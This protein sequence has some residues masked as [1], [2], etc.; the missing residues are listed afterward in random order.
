MGFSTSRFN[1]LGYSGKLLLYLQSHYLKPTRNGIISKTTLSK[2]KQ[3]TILNWILIVSV[4]QICILACYIFRPLG[5]MHSPYDLKAQNMA[6]LLKNEQAKSVWLSTISKHTSDMYIHV[7]LTQYEIALPNAY[8]GDMGQIITMSGQ[9]C[10]YSFDYLITP[11]SKKDEKIKN[12]K[13]IELVN[14][15]SNKTLGWIPL[16]NL[17]H[18]DQLKLGTQRYDIYRV[19]CN[20]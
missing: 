1:G 2:P 6:I 7:V 3:E 19:L 11:Y 20:R 18:I 5:S 16:A 17:Q 14:D 9:Y 13:G 15:V 8:Y 10:G 12:E 4:L